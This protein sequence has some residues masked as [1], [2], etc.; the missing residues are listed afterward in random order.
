MNNLTHFTDYIEYYKNLTNPGYAVLVT[1]EWGSGKTYQIKK[2]LPAEQMYY[3]S[4]F[5]ITSVE[6]IYASV[7]YKMSPAKAFTKNAASSLGDASIGT[8]AMTFGLGGILGKVVS[9]VIKE[10]VKT[11]RVIVFD[12]LERCDV[13]INN[14]L[15]AINKYV[16]HHGC[17]V[18][19]IAHDTKITDSFSD[20]K[21]KVIGQT[22]K[23]EPD[24]TEIFNFFIQQENRGDIPK[25]ITDTVL[26]TFLSSACK[27]MRILK[28]AIKDSFRL[29]D[30]IDSKYRSNLNV[31]DEV[32][33]FF[34]ALSVE[35]R[36]GG[37]RESDLTGRHQTAIMHYIADGKDGKKEAPPLIKLSERYS[38]NGIKIDFS[39]NILND[40]TISNCLVKGYYDRQSINNDVSNNRFLDSRESESWLRLMNFDQKSPDEIQLAIEDIDN[41]LKNHK[42]IDTGVLIHIFSLKLLM[43]SIK[44]HSLSYSE[45]YIQFKEYLRQLLDKNL[46]PPS[47]MNGRS[48]EFDD[49]S[50]GYRYWIVEEAKHYTYK[51]IKLANHFSKLALQKKYPEFISEVMESLEST[52]C[53]F[54]QLVAPSYNSTGKYAYLDILR[55][56]KPYKFVEAWLKCPHANHQKISQGLNERYTANALYNQLSTEVKWVEQVNKTLDH[57][58]SASSGFEQLKLVRLKVRERQ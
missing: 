17:K 58:A 43:T 12:D 29:F 22:L 6:E 28:H 45:V 42:I 15:G 50:H 31:M 18:I 54:S 37:I 25:I 47:E 56:V 35:Y 24:T 13:D 39:R 3:V 9:A 7:F 8:D 19:A 2:L 30:C 23:I 41:E 27:S 55:H 32:F 38:K 10:D 26:K 34:T 11:D 48:S 16:E 4:L 33:T 21:E 57:Y 46:L 40:D 53:N 49:T 14:I 1:G 51:M 44:A 5:D 20:A 52:P 36:Y